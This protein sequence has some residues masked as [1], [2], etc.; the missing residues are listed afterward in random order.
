LAKLLAI[1]EFPPGRARQKWCF[2][3]KSG[4]AGDAHGKI[5]GASHHEEF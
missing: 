4:C 3:C 2:E 1:K 5:V